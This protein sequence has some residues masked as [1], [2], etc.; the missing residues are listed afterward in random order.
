MSS[1]SGRLIES[2]QSPKTGVRSSDCR[3]LPEAI[4]VRSYRLVAFVV[5]TLFFGYFSTRFPSFGGS[6]TAG[7]LNRLSARLHGRVNT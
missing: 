1:T 4:K 5:S 6:A 3:T 7:V 2:S